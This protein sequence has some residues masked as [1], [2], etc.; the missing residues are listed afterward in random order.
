MLLLKTFLLKYMMHLSPSL[1]ICIDTSSI[2]FVALLAKSYYKKAYQ[3]NFKA[4]PS[5]M[6]REIDISMVSKYTL[7]L[8]WKA[9]STN[10]EESRGELATGH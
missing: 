4:T 2:I 8:A 10:C 9:K 5:V 6:S 1:Y 7:T 3:E